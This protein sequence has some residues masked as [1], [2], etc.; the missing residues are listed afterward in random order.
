[1]L[2]LDA[3]LDDNDDDNY[4]TGDQPQ[5]MSN[6]GMF[7]INNS[8]KFIWVNV[9]PGTHNVKILMRSAN[10]GNVSANRPTMLIYYVP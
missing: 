2:S 4:I 3:R 8:V 1:M 10:G 5:L 9:A 6:S 7:S